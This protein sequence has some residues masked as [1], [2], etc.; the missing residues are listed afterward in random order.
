ML[1]DNFVPWSIVLAVVFGLRFSLSIETVRDP[2]ASASLATFWLGFVI[3]LVFS[4]FVLYDCTALA[5]GIP[6]FGKFDRSTLLFGYLRLND[7]SSALL[8]RAVLWTLICITVSVTYEYAS[9]SIAV[10]AA[11][12]FVCYFGFGTHFCSE[13]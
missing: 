13:F 2:T 12:Y 5:P 7:P 1:R 6:G 4:A 3:E 9:L 8:T 11:L 10:A